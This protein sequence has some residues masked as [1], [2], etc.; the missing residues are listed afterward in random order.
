MIVQEL[1]HPG[2][3]C[4]AFKCGFRRHT[5]VGDYCVS[6]VGDYWPRGDRGERETIGDGRT[7]ETMVFRLLRAAD[8]RHR[9][10]PRCPSGGVELDMVPYN[11]EEDAQRGHDSVVLAIV[12][13]LTYPLDPARADE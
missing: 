4:G 11:S 2:H 7:F 1:P 6:T 9:C 8:T 10:C 5:H 13:G 3:F 12:R